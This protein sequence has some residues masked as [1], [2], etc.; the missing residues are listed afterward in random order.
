[1][2]VTVVTALTIGIP[3]FLLALDD[4]VAAEREARRAIELDPAADGGYL[5]LIDALRRQQRHRDAIGSAG[6]ADDAEAVFL[7]ALQERPGHRP[8]LLGLAVLE[9]MPSASAATA[10]AVNPRLCQNMRRE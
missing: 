2:L 7:R 10:A 8:A 6:R 5:I 4:D 3:A 1:M 9:P